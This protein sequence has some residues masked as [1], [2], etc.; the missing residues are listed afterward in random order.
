MRKLFV[1]FTFISFLSLAQTVTPTYLKPGTWRAVLL[2]DR[3]RNIEVPFKLGLILKNKN[4]L[5]IV[6]M[7]EKIVVDEITMQ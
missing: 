6:K 5:W 2:L 3:D 1:I 4:D 7:V